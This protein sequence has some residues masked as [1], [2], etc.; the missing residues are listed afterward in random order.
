M[1]AALDSPF[2]YA[3]YFRSLLV[4]QAFCEDEKE[5]FTFREPEFGEGLFQEGDLF[6][7]GEFFER[8]RH[9]GIR[10]FRNQIVFFLVISGYLFD[11]RVLAPH[12]V[13]KRIMGNAVKVRRELRPDTVS[14]RVAP[15]FEKDVLCEV[16]GLLAAAADPVDKVADNEVRVTFDEAAEGFRV[17][18]VED[19]VT[20]GG[21]VQETMDIV[22]AHGGHVVG[23]AMAVN[24]SGGTV[25]FGVPMFS[26]LSLH[27]ETFPAD[28]LP[29]DLA[30][31]PAEKPG[32]N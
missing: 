9:T 22:R 1:E 12:E 16:F 5:G 27:V 13:N 30:A 11:V 14:G 4:G 6:V 24:R 29:P 10:R 7:E 32:S 3:E 8:F 25:D 26:L 20:K 23:A 21:R 19:V 31:V 18:R 17:C 2:G 28:K 15:E